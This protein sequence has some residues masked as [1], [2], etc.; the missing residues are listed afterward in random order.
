M[1]F[2]RATN[3]FGRFAS[4]LFRRLFIITAQFHFTETSFTLHF[5]FQ[6]AQ[7]LLDVIIMH[8]DG[9]YGTPLLSKKLNNKRFVAHF[10]AKGKSFFEKNFSKGQKEA[11]SRIW[12]LKGPP[13]LPQPS[14]NVKFERWSK[15]IE[16]VN[17]QSL[18]PLFHVYK[19]NGPFLLTLTETILKVK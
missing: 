18:N 4:L 5:L 14:K 17:F 6:N 19:K 16:S 12:G 11:A 15:G 8:N 10:F 3:A 7:R 13:N 9:D 1:H 2:A